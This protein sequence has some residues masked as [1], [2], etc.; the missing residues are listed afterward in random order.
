MVTLALL[1]Q[2]D[3]QRLREQDAANFIRERLSPVAEDP[4]KSAAAVPSRA[5]VHVEE[6]SRTKSLLNR[7][8]NSDRIP[9]PST[10]ALEAGTLAPD[11]SLHTT[12]DQ[13]ISL[14]ELRGA[15]VI[16]TFYP[17]DWSPVCGDQLAL[18]NELMP[19]FL[20]FH[21]SLVGV[22][23]DGVW[24]HLAY[25]KDRKLRFPL[26]ADF[27]PKGEV[28]R[29]Y[30]VYRPHDGITERAI[31]VIDADGTIRWS[32]VSPIGVNPGADGILTALNALPVRQ[33]MTV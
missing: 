17:A 9:Q 21:A 24:C 4:A 6:H 11:F 7:S 30:G 28:A 5:L 32:Y 1:V 22:S 8:P 2:L 19:E 27:E 12:P 31:F 29:S 20:R 13:L 14:H 23:V 10:S 33:E 26:L 25:S 16:L 18:Y 3:A 15:P